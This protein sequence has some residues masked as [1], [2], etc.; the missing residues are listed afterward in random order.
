MA[1]TALQRKIMRRVYYAYT[2]AIASHTMF[3]QGMLLGACIALFGR[4]THVASLIHN[5]LSVP[6]GSVP[7]YVGGA[8][9]TAF[10]HG[11]MLTVLVT[12]FMLVLAL[13]VSVRLVHPMLGMLSARKVA[14]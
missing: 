1:T 3:W 13:S 5:L 11:E 2:I 8:F 6:V 10:S 14:I 7:A 4:L 9:S 12:A